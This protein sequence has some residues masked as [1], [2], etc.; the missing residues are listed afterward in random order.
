MDVISAFPITVL[1]LVNNLFVVVVG[2]DTA[3]A[4]KSWPSYIV[5]I[6]MKFLASLLPILVAMAVSNLVTVLKYT[7][8]LALLL[9]LFIPAMLQL[10]SQWACWKTFKPILEANYQPEGSSISHVD[11]DKAQPDTEEGSHV[12]S[13]KAQPEAEERS[14]VDS[15]KAQPD[16][17]ERS[18]LIRSSSQVKPSAL[19]MTP[20]SHI[21]SYWP[22]VV[23]LIAV[24][25]VMLALTVTSFFFSH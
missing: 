17:E 7:G 9:T 25:V 19:Y 4:R 3:Q 13:D 16:T 14:H 10:S 11:S 2:K 12:D 21:F 1:T 6:L 24:Y 18:L 20:Y 23:I 5:Y 8:F 22:V 15:D